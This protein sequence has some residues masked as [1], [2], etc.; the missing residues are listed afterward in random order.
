ML[1]EQSLDNRMQ[2]ALEF[3]AKERH[4]R[5]LRNSIQQR[6]HDRLDKQQ[7]DFY[8]REQIRALQGELDGTEGGGDE[9]SRI[10]VK[11][12]SLG[13][14]DGTL[15]EALKEVTRMRR[16]PPDAAEYNVARTWPSGSSA[17]LG[18]LHPMPQTSTGLGRA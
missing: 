3:I 8:L 15:E 13:M 17:C 2:M 7:R 14:P 10:E 4:Y 9:A 1:A 6:T 12:K 11:L 5:T 18:Y 16:M